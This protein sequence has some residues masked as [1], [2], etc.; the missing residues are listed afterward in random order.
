MSGVRMTRRWL[1]LLAW[2]WILGVIFATGSFG[3]SV[4]S[5]GWIPTIAMAGLGFLFAIVDSRI[6]RTLGGSAPSPAFA[7]LTAFPYL[8]L[9]ARS[10]P[11]QYSGAWGPMG[12][13]AVGTVVA[14]VIMGTVNLLGAAIY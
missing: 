2:A 10:D 8:A 3:P 4:G 11:D 1:W 14:L 5:G 12:L 9:R 6:A 13:A 7:L